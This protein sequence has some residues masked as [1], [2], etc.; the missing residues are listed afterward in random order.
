MNNPS[1]PN[2][3][4]PKTAGIAITSLVLGIISYICLLGP[5]TAIPAIIC[6]HVARKRIR[7]SEGALTGEGFGL[8]GLILGYVNLAILLLIIPLLLAIAIPNFVKARSTASVNS[9]INNLRQLDGATAQWAIENKKPEGSLV[10]A[11]D[12]NDYLKNGTES[13]KCP[14]GGEYT[15]GPVG[16]DPTCS[17][18]GHELPY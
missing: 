15:I 7:N 2:P 4:Q 17:V 1:Y 11:S 18:E 8:A 13:L 6:G 16:E 12:I 3:S 9:C 5:F 10:T 14:Q